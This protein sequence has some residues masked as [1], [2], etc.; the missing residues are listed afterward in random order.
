MECYQKL[1]ARLGSTRFGVYL[2][3]RRRLRSR[4]GLVARL[5]REHRHRFGRHAGNAQKLLELVV[6]V[7]HIEV[8][9]VLQLSNKNQFRKKRNFAHAA[10]VD[11]VE[12]RSLLDFSGRFYAMDRQNPQLEHHCRE[13]F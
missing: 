1:N 2:C 11:L 7:G 6:L 5:F 12:G 4:S 10:S 9:V 13:T 3:G 8:I